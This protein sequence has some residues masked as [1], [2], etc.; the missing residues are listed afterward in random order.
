MILNTSQL[1]LNTLERKITPLAA[2]LRFTVE[3]RISIRVLAE[4]NRYAED[5]ID[6][7]NTGYH[8]DLNRDDF[9]NGIFFLR[10]AGIITEERVNQILNSPILETEI[11]R[12]TL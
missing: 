1:T 6:L 12:G 3:E 7:L 8:V 11:Y 5:F 4:T 2:K 9:K 10:N